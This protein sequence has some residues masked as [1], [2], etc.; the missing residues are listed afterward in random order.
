MDPHS[1]TPWDPTREQLLRVAGH[2]PQTCTRIPHSLPRASLLTDV[3]CTV[4]VCVCCT[5]ALGDG[6]AY[7]ATADLG[8]PATGACDVHPQ[9]K[10]GMGERM[11]RSAERIVYGDTSEATLWRHP[12]VDG[13]DV[14]AFVYHA[15]PPLQSWLSDMLL[16]TS[17]PPPNE[18][19]LSHSSLSDARQAHGE[20]AASTREKYRHAWTRE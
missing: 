16:V 17:A 4:C 3:R 5:G 7:A 11:A 15:A 8:G 1:H 13:A 9:D 2:G 12:R 10:R 14:G 18:R 19:S 20:H 6:V